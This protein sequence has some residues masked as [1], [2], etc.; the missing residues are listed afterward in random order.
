[1]F[2]PE[3]MEQA[4]VAH[5]DESGSRVESKLWWLHS[6]S[7]AN[8]TDYDIHRKRGSEAMDQ[9]GILPDFT[10]RAVHDFWKPYFGDCCVHG[11]CNAHYADLRI[12]PTCARKPAPGVGLVRIRS[13]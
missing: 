4:S 5:F 7:T 11:L 3:H 6:A 12:M 9:I 8:A 2:S 1:M 13:A 10:G